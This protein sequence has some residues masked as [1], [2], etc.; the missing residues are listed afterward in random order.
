MGIEAQTT[1][2]RNWL[3]RP[4]DVAGLVFFRVFFGATIAVVSARYLV[5]GWVDAF[6]VRPT[7]H[8]KF[9]GFH[10]IEVAPGWALKAIL[11]VMVVLG[12]MVAVG[13]YYRLATVL[14]AIGFL[15]IELLDATYYLNHY[16]LVSLLCL[17]AA[18]L[19]LHRACSR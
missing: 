8:F 10:W 9:W 15:Y 2:L 7:F 12:L 4:T 19:P 5:Y 14:V 3:S 18:V 13:V 11:T 16:Y 1:P 6:F 17:H